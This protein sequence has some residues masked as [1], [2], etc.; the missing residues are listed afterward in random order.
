[1]KETKEPKNGRKTD[2]W[3]SVGQEKKEEEM[4]GREE[5]K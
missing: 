5:V 1:M 4:I 3:K 2:R